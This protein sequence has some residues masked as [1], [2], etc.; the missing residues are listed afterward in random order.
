MAK[1]SPKRG[2]QDHSDPKPPNA[3]RPQGNLKAREY[4][5]FTQKGAKTQPIGLIQIQMATLS[6][7]PLLYATATA[8]LQSCSF[9]GITLSL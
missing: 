4:K 1:G 2:Y 7:W 3:W 5:C 6:C 8:E 9:C